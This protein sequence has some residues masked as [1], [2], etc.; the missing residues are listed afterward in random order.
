MLQSEEEP[1]SGRLR[2]QLEVNAGNQDK[3][4]VFYVACC[5]SRNDDKLEVSGTTFIPLAGD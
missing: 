5:N 2:Y 3:L 4:V 1:G